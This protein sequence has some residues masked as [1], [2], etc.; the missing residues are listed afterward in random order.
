MYGRILPAFL[1][2]F[3]AFAARPA[4][5]AEDWVVKTSPHSVADTVG[6]LTGAIENAG[7]NV[8]AVVD[9]A[10]AAE[11]AGL[12]LPPTTVVIFGNPKVGTP[13]MADNR[14]IALDLPMKVLVWQW[15]EETRI[16]YVEPAELAQRYGFD[17]DHPSIQTMKGALGKLTDAAVA[18]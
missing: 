9:H 7:A 11:K 17:A 8:A 1:I 3:F 10:A 2:A 15:G 18:E 14:N 5:A 4:D 6:K 16:G 13:L 12:E